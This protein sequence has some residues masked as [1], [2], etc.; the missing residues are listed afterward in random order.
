MGNIAASLAALLLL[1]QPH[2][3]RAA[4]PRCGGD[5]WPVKTLTDL[6][7]DRVSL[8]PVP[9]SIRTLTAI[10]IPDVPYPANRRLAPQELTTY[11]IRGQLVSRF[12]EADQ[13][14]HLV[15]A[16]PDVA[17]ATMIVEVPLSACAA[18]SPLQQQ[19]RAARTIALAV[20]LSS[21][22]TVTGVGFFDF[23]HT[24]RRQAPNGFELHPVFEVVAAPS[25]ASPTK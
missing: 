7:R 15:L 11:T 19:F 6:D 10:Q 9:T 24:A 2:G 14:V 8:K 1:P 3:D 22:V 12:I 20:P 4:P 13:D 5:R 17:N 21:A 16:D 23:L 25:R 18:G